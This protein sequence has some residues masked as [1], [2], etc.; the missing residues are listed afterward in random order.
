MG[1]NYRRCKGGW[2]DRTPPALAPIGDFNNWNGAAYPEPSWGE[3][4]WSS[5]RNVTQQ[6][7]GY[8]YG[9]PRNLHATLRF[10]F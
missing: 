3:R 4:F 1:A 7:A 9:E 8:V 5:G 2:S 6:Y 10:D